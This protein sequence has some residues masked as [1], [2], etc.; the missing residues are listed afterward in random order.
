MDVSPAIENTAKDDTDV[1]SEEGYEAALPTSS[2]PRSSVSAY[3]NPHYDCIPS[4]G[5]A[6]DSMNGLSAYSEASKCPLTCARHVDV[7]SLY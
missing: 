7:M 4:D 3:S 5:V 1:T 6:T 2:E